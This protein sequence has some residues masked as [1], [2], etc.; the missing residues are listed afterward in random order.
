[1]RLTPRGGGDCLDGVVE[2]A[3][4]R[5]WLAARVSAAPEGGKANRALVKMLAKRLGVPPRD[6]EI[7]AGASSRQKRLRVAGLS[8]VAAAQR[9]QS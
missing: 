7:V 1:M 5:A 9:L 3:D 4:G 8:A 2:T 6:I